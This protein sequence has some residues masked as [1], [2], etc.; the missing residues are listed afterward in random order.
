MKKRNVVCVGRKVLCFCAAIILVLTVFGSRALCVYA[1][2]YAITGASKQGT[3]T[4]VPLKG[5]TTANGYYTLGGYQ[6]TYTIEKDAWTAYYDVFKGGFYIGNNLNTSGGCNFGYHSGDGMISQGG[7]VQL[8]SMSDGKLVAE[9]DVINNKATCTFQ[10]NSL[11]ELP[12]YIAYAYQPA[13]GAYLHLGSE[14]GNMYHIWHYQTLKGTTV[15]N[16]PQ[17]DT[18][19]PTLRLNAEPVGTTVVANGKTWASQMAIHATANDAKAGVQGITIYQNGNTV[20]NY[21]NTVQ[22]ASFQASHVVTENG[23]YDAIAYDKLNNRSSKITVAI[24][25]IDTTAPVIKKVETDQSDFCLANKIT[26]VSHDDQSGL[27]EAAYS[28]NGSEWTDSPEYE[29]AE[30]GTYELKVRDALGNETTSTI[31]I[32]NIDNKPPIIEEVEE[33]E[34]I[35]GKIKLQIKATDNEGGAGLHESPYS[36]DGGKTWQTQPYRYIEKNGMYLI[37]VRDAL[38]S[39]ADTQFEVK[40][41]KT[42]EEIEEPITPD[43]PERPE[44]PD[45]PMKPSIPNNPVIDEMTDETDETVL[46]DETD[47]MDDHAYDLLHLPRLERKSASVQIE[48]NLTKPEIKTPGTIL[49]MQPIRK[50]SVPKVALAVLISAFVM[51]LLGL[52]LY[53]WLFYLQRSCVLYGVDDKQERIRICRLPIR[54]YDEEWQVKVSEDRLGD[55][56][57]GKYVLVF[58]PSFVKEEMPASVIIVIAERSI[59]EILDQEV[60]FCI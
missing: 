45:M 35:S 40:S 59:R 13:S 12:T 28:W 34:D 37:C 23:N 39:K 7:A 6:V 8:G 11:S 14:K 24:N 43:I 29:A 42:A 3:V 16:V 57:T 38:E 19:A 21:K 1:Y 2:S 20:G 53:L 33:T 60:S 9:A 44:S 36:F 10:V 30:N 47:E 32:G 17:I 4:I 46:R 22:A 15:S 31:E 48:E 5:T 54:R 41:V 51:G 25:G 52:I 49:N 58:H 50:N 27:A 26:V 55:H 56:G 18:E